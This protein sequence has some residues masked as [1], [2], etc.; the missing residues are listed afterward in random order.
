MNQIIE[1]NRM[2]LSPVSKNDAE[3]LHQLWA[4]PAVRKYLCDD[5]IVPLS[6]IE[7]IVAQ[8]ITAFEEKRYGIWIARLKHS[9]AIAGF[10]GY[11]PFFEPPEIQ[12][13]YGLAPDLWGQ[14]LG[15]EMARAM[16]NYGF[17][18]Y[19]FETVRASA[20]VPNVASIAIMKRLG[21]TFDRQITKDGQD[22]VFY[23]ISSLH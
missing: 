4:Q 8:S 6:Q 18:A 16:L 17:K 2:L 23:Q 7:E 21:M 3:E 9:P 1:T 10:T 5:S 13:I 11:W 19:G 22:L 14:G 20:D 12:L 15:T